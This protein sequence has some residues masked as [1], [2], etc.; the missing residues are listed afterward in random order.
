MTNVQKLESWIKNQRENHGLID[1]RFDSVYHDNLLADNLVKMGVPEGEVAGLRVEVPE[2]KEQAIEDMAGE[3]L[4]AINA[5]K[6][7]DKEFF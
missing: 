7:E 5:P 3:I 6:L 4:A 1:F 2:N